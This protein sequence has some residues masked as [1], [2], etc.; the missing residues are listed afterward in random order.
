[1]IYVSLYLIEKHIL[2]FS[3][4]FSK[5]LQSAIKCLDVLWFAQLYFEVLALQFQLPIRKCL[6]P[7]IRLTIAFLMIRH[8][9]L[10]M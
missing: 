5:C 8:I 9:F 1:L 10:T 4:I 2:S 6:L 7:V 3:P